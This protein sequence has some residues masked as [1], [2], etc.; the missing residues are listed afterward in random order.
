MILSLPEKLLS[1]GENYWDFDGIKKDGIHKLANYPAMMVAP[2]QNKL[3][4]DILIS[5]GN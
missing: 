3:I 1:Y 4:E 5:E 2:M